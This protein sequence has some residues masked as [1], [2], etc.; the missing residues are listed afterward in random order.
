MVVIKADK[1]PSGEQA[2]RYNAPT[3]NEVAVVTIGERRDVPIHRR[4]NKVHTIQD[5]HCSYDALQYAL[6]FREGEDGYHF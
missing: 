2:G 5:S 4:D 6:I 3:I 1:V